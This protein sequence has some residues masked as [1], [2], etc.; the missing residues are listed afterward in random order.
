MQSP[1]RL[2]GPRLMQ[3]CHKSV[4]GLQVSKFYQGMGAILGPKLQQAAAKITARS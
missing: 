2:V 4:K 1:E 3:L